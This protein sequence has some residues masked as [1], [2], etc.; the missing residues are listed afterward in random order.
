MGLGSSWSDVPV[1]P[2]DS[3]LSVLEASGFVFLVTPASWCGEPDQ[4]MNLI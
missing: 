1:G 3:C 2:R 4:G